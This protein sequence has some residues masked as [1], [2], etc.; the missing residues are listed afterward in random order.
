MR[1]IQKELPGLTLTH[2]ASASL[3][4]ALQQERTATKSLLTSVGKHVIGKTKTTA[5]VTAFIENRD[6]KESVL[7]E[8]RAL[9]NFKPPEKNE[10]IETMIQKQKES[11][12]QRH[13][14]LLKEF[15]G[16]IE[17]LYDNLAT[18]GEDLIY[19]W[20][21]FAKASQNELDKMLDDLSD[22]ILLQKELE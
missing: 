5:S 2:K 7:G 22:D 21:Q 18:T 11:R 3:H 20:E 9:S 15:E 16:W 14:N 12:R 17:A 8:V 19:K 6:M 13:L 1:G 10:K 4:S